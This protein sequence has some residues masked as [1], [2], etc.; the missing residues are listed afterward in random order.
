VHESQ[1]SIDDVILYWWTND[2][3]Y[4]EI[5]AEIDDLEKIGRLDIYA[6]LREKNIPSGIH[7]AKHW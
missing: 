6:V 7:V 2:V 4:K 5:A 1:D 3:L